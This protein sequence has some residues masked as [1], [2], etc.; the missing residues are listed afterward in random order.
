MT[1]TE[2]HTMKTKTPQDR[3]SEFDEQ[4]T[5][6]VQVRP[7]IVK[8]LDPKIKHHLIQTILSVLQ[9]QKTVVEGMKIKESHI[10]IGGLY[11]AQV[12]LEVNQALSDYKHSLEEVISDWEKL[13]N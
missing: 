9:E 8:Q 4:F 2:K 1:T 5:E 13:I 3:L 10:G 7:K 6:I 12:Q 11:T